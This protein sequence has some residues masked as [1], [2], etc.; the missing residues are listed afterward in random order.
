MKSP[1]FIIPDDK[2]YDKKE[3]LCSLDELSSGITE[4]ANTLDLEA[5]CTMFEFP[6]YG[7]F[8]RLEII[9]FVVYHTR[10]HIHQL[11][12]IF[13]KLTTVNSL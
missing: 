9:Y 10:R 13:E 4:A 7:Y 1:E 6:Y 5:T 11:Q 8:T 2:N 12:N 3:L